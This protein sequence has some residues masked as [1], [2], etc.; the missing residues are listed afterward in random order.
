M[1]GKIKIIIT[2][3]VIIYLDDLVQILYKKEYFGFIESAEDYVSKIYDI[4]DENI[5]L[6]THKTTPQK[7]K[8]LGSN[9]IFYK[10]NKR[11][12]WYI[13]FEKKNSNYL[14]T[15]II[16]NHCEQAKNL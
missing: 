15:G 3:K 16:N 1:V 14:V 11:T 13:F 6:S 2:P 4:L 7:L 10:S 5:K 9:Y 12:T 8:Y